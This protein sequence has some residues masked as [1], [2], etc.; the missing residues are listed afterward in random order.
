MWLLTA[1][2]SLRM[3][4]DRAALVESCLALCDRALQQLGPDAR[5]I[6]WAT[7]QMLRGDALRE[8]ARGKRGDNLEE[9]LAAYREALARVRK[10]EHLDTWAQCKLGVGLAYAL[11]QTGEPKDNQLR[12]IENLTEAVSH[13]DETARLE[14]ALGRLHLAR[15]LQRRG[16]EGDTLR[17]GELY[18]LAV[19]VFTAKDHPNEYQ[20]CHD[21]IEQLRR[22]KRIS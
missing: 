15:L 6:E 18:E 4:G 13:L 16:Q 3:R 1:E 12:A 7:A 22:P 5:T 8:R 11:R 21:G 17:I 14:L 9:A 20:L 2:A 19:K 10:D